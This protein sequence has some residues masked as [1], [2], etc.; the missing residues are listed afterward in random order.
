MEMNRQRIILTGAAGGMGA[1][2]AQRLASLG[3]RLLLVDI[4]AEAVESVCE[5]IREQGG[6]AHPVAADLSTIAGC[7]SVEAEALRTL[8]GI[9]ILINLAGML[10]FSCFEDMDPALLDKLLKV[11]L[12]APAVLT[13]KILPHMLEQKRGH[14][15]NVGSI[16]GSIAFAHFAAYSASKFGLRG[17]SEALRRELDGSGVVVTY[18]APRAV[19]TALNTGPIVAM[20]EATGVAMDDPAIVVDK[21][22]AA[23]EKERKEVYI[24]WPE[25]LFVRINALLPRLVDRAVAGKN[26]IAKRFAKESIQRSEK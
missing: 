21:I 17:L 4:N 8:G 26:R 22:I 15:V 20:N 24:G 13:R 23:M 2:L 3:A 1:L 11:N 12:V 6:E 18:V 16:F 5:T 19:K 14:I 7:D 10:S 25:S 9:D